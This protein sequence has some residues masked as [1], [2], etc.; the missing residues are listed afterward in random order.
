MQHTLKR[1]TQCN[2]EIKEEFPNKCRINYKDNLN[3]LE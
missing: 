1:M 3:K 2:N